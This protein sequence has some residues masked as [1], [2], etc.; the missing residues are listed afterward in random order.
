MHDNERKTNQQICLKELRSW[1]KVLGA[2]C[3][4]AKS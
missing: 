4:F 2:N 1:E 3:Y